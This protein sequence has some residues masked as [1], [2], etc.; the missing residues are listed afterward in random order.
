MSG[1]VSLVGAGPGDPDLL[2]VRA[3][4]ALAE[5]DL[6]L[7]DALVVAGGARRWRPRAQRF[8]V[9]KRAG[10]PSMRQET[11]HRLMVRA[12]RRGKRVV[13]LKGGD[14]FV[15]RPRR[16]GGAG[17]RRGG[18]PV[19]GGAR[20][21]R[22]A[23]AAPAL[24]GIPVTHRG[25]ASAFVV[26]SGHAETRL[27]AGAR[28]AC[29]PGVADRGRAHG[30]RARAARSR[31]CCSRAAGRR[32][33]RRD[34]AGGAHARSRAWIGHARRARR[35]ADPPEPTDAPGTIVVGRGRRPRRD[36]RRR[37]AD[38]PTRSATWS[39]HGR[40]EVRH[41]DSTT[42]TTLGRARLS[43]ADEAEIDEFVAT[44]ERF[45]RGELDARPVARLPPRARHLRP[46]P[47]GRRRRC[48]A[49]RSRRGSSTAP[50]LDALA[51]V[52]E[53]LLARLRPHHHPP[54]RAVPLREAARRR[55]GACGGWPRPGL[56]TREAC[57][58]SVRN[59]T[60][61]PY[62]GVAADELFDVTP[63]AEALTRYLLRH[64]LA[65]GAAAQVQDRLRGLPRRTTRSPRSTTSAGARACARPAGP[66][67]AS[68]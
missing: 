25:L 4:R 49:S 20:A 23:V 53:T 42:Q 40:K 66:S 68:A 46:A 65:R 44:L 38:E 34:P 18:H 30:P 13:R 57:G 24:A 52:A 48:C 67:A 32:D 47:D 11:I 54:E 63:Y 19:R 55:E 58:N 28:R 45:E 64:P 62:A 36:A 14:P 8:R 29:A 37:L 22:S 33:T 59:I 60:A 16:R 6:V 61:C 1:F 21:S 17:P 50:Q 15:L 41:A 5:A 27:A 43:F 12:A 10:R 56:T 9:G 3:A 39:R 35:G 2:T 51:D 7:Y 26:V 31:R